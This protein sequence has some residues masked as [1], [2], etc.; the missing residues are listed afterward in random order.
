MKITFCSLHKYWGG[1]APNGGTQTILRSADT[2]RKLGHEVNVV[3]PVD[4]FKWFEH[5]K[6]LKKI[7]EDTDVCVAISI[8]DVDLLMKEAPKT[9]KLAYW[10]R[11]IEF[12]QFEK[13]K[14]ISILK[15]FKRHGKIFTNSTWQVDYMDAYGIKSEVIYNGIDFDKWKELG[16]KREAI[17][18]LKHAHER[19]R[20]RDCKHLIKKIK[21]REFLKLGSKKHKNIVGNKLMKFYNK[22]N[23]WFAPTE[24]E[25]FHN[26]PAE[27]NLCGCLIIGSS[28]YRNG[29]GDYLGKNTGMVYDSLDEAI[30]MIK[31]P[32]YSKV[33]KMQ[34]VLVNKIGTRKKNMEKLVECLT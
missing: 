3:A 5:P 14:A 11:P 32:D 17:G 33:P 30:D 25:G 18:C 27:A 8:S 9:A 10:A 34:E 19:K 28:C 20:Y 2:L 4:R 7:P 26:V 1:L 12:W 29:M 31:K 6:P 13:K 22:C 24:L 16:L 23:I 21:W 15:R